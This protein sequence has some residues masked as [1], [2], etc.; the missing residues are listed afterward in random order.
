[1]KDDQIEDLSVDKGGIDQSTK[2]YN[3]QNRSAAQSF[4]I[5]VRAASSVASV[6]E[7]NAP[8]TAL[9]KRRLKTGKRGEV[10]KPA[11]QSRLG[12]KVWQWKQGLGSL[13]LTIP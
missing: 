8:E 13:G 7:V 2:L 10:G 5:E 1:L 6:Y 3:E 4:Y 11:D 12:G 9:E